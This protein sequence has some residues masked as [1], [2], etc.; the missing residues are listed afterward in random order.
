MIRLELNGRTESVS[1]NGAES[2]L[3]LL[4]ERLGCTS[5]KAA[6][7]EGECGSC[8]VML[9]GELVCSCLVLAADANECRVVTTEGLSPAQGLNDVQDALLRASG[10]QCGFCT[11][12]FIVAISALLAKNPTPSEADIREEL[13]GNLCR[14]TGYQAILQAVLDGMTET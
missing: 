14:C 4:R 11:P 7:E 12:G 2:L 6:C 1:V 8:S 3:H 13:A 9:D 5:V 10:I